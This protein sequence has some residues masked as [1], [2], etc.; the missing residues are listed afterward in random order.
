MSPCDRGVPMCENVFAAID[1]TC[2]RELAGSSSSQADHQH[3]LASTSLAAHP[4]IPAD[5]NIAR[6]RA[7]LGI[8]LYMYI[9]CC[10]FSC[11][12]IQ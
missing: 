1:P 12:M 8:F 2:Q 3:H 4:V 10:C 5:I 7:P 9:S 6:R 11:S